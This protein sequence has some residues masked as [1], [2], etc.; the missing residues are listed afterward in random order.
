MDHVVERREREIRI[1]RAG[2]VADEQAKC[3]HLARFAGFDDQ[4]DPRARALA[5]Q[6]MMHGA[7]RAGSESARIRGSRRDRT[8]R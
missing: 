8:A 5:D 1:D 7:S 4:A 3:M 2:A 6:M